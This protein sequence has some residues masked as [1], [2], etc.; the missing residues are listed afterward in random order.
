MSARIDVYKDN[1]GEWRWHLIAGNGETIASGEGHT[2]KHD[3]ARAAKTVRQ[4]MIETSEGELD[5]R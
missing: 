1:S 3:A 5:G 4:R 2:T